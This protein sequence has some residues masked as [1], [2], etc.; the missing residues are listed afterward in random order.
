G[1]GGGKICF[2]AA[3]IVGPTGCVIGVD[4]NPDMLALARKYLPE[5]ADKLGYANV[6]FRA[7]M[8]QDLKL[9]LDRLAN[10]LQNSP[11][12]TSADWIALRQLEQQL[13]DESPLIADNSVDCVVSNC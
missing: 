5:M 13:R 1:S 11:I 8:I 2:I 7:G 4:Y 6:E 9:D 3:Q 12:Q 10:H